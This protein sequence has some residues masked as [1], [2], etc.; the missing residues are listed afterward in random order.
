MPSSLVV[1]VSLYL[2]VGIESWWK[3]NVGVWVGDENHTHKNINTFGV[4]NASKENGS[5]RDNKN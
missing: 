2:F 4:E 5:D 1:C 3:G